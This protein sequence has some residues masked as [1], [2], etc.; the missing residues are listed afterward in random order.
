MNLLIS[1]QGDLL[2]ITPTPDNAK[3]HQLMLR[4]PVLIITKR[5]ELEELPA[6]T[7]EAL[8][9]NFNVRSFAMLWK[10]IKDKKGLPKW[11]KV[12]VKEVLRCLYTRDTKLALT[13]DEL[14]EAVPGASWISIVTA[15]SM[16][17]NAKYAD[18]PLLHIEQKGGKYRRVDSG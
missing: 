18:G 3:R 14:L 17:K 10:Q 16:L 9:E 8:F 11:G 1:P 5:S 4:T 15:I 7:T 6:K 13:E 2:G 12:S